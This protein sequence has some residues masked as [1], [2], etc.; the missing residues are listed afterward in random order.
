MVTHPLV[1]MVRSRPKYRLAP[2]ARQRGISMI[3]TL[4][5][6]VILAFAAVMQGYMS[7]ATITTNRNARNITVATN[8]A[9]HKLEELKS[10]TYTAVTSGTDGPLTPDGSAGGAYSR[11]WTVTD[12]VPV[13]GAKTVDV[14]VSWADAADNRTV[15]VQSVIAQ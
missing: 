6:V 10:G 1:P 12:N 11:A 14:T 13:T 8:L 2:A 3:E 7:L 9:M 5:A 15:S 4:V